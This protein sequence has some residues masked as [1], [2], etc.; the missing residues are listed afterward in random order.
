M[1]KAMYCS[2]FCNNN[3]ELETNGNHQGTVWVSNIQMMTYYTAVREW[4]ASLLTDVDSTPDTK[5]IK[6][7]G[8][9]YVWT[10]SFI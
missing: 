10:L 2:E 3:E 6:Q 1:H 4:G 8:K 5:W 7:K 9:K